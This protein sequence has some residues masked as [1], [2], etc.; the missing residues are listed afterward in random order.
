MEVNTVIYSYKQ[1]QCSMKTRNYKIGKP[2]FFVLLICILTSCKTVPMQQYDGFTQGT[3]YSIKCFDRENRDLQPAIDSLLKDFDFTASIFNPNSL[4]SKVNNNHSNLV[5]NADFRYLFALSMEISKATEGAFDITV[6]RLVN[7]W[8]FGSDKR[9][10]LRAEE[11]DSLLQYVGY[12]KV[13]L[14]NNA[15]IKENSAIKLDFNA[16]AKGYSVDKMGDFL[17]SLGIENYIVDIGGEVLAKGNKNG[18]NWI[19]AIERPAT[20][21]NDQQHALTTISLNN[22]ALATSG[23]Y[24]KYYEKDGIKYS[25]TICPQ[26]GYP[27]KHNLLSVTVKHDKTAVAD[28]YATA[29]MVMGLEKSLEFLKNH[30]DM[31]AFFIYN[32]D[33]EMKT[34]EV[35]EW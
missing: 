16:I 17:N 21:K 10:D 18:K 29:F 11:I 14:E 6:G 3:Y 15:V 30:S 26:T 12:E 27:V 28:A 31:E 5:L 32:E 13:R 24:R 2:I 22:R 19:V 20:G 4:I 25:H 7:A 9:K 8:G 33:G 1:K 23:N 34:R 35:G